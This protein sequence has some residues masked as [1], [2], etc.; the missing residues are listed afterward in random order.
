MY[1]GLIGGEQGVDAGKHPRKY[2]YWDMWKTTFCPQF[3]PLSF[4]FLLWLIITVVFAVLL[5]VMAMP[6]KQLNEN[7]FLGPDL[8]TLHAW[9]ALDPYMI[10]YNYQIWRLFTSLFISIGFME[11]IIAS[12]TLLV[13]G[14]IVENP[15]MS[16]YKMAIM[17]FASGILGNLFSI[18]VQ[19]EISVG[20][21]PGIMS[22]TSGL[23]SS[24]IVNWKAL[25]GVGFMRV[26]LIF[27]VVLLFLLLLL[28]SY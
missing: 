24:I 13:I 5:G 26:C 2:N 1:G 28:L 11:Y 27:M 10:R 25:A 9:G 19:S 6:E 20:P 3:S 8:K 12:G 14:S 17:F 18:C 4:T 15:K 23:I 21:M 16:A 22:L 7:L